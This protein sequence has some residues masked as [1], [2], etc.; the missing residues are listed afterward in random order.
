MP[1]PQEDLSQW[2]KPKTQD[3]S[4]GGAVATGILNPLATTNQKVTETAQPIKE[5]LSKWASPKV[6]AVN[7]IM[8]TANMFHEQAQP[9]NLIPAIAGTAATIGT[10]GLASSLGWSAGKAM[11][12]RILAN[13]MVNFGTQAT[14]N[15]DYVKEHPGEA[16][17]G[18]GVN[19]LGSEGVGQGINWAAGGL[20]NAILRSQFPINRT[21]EDL[22]LLR[23]APPN[24]PYTVG[25]AQGESNSALR[26]NS[27]SPKGK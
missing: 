19:A 4:V 10:D 8:K 25:Q 3:S 18:A 1:D 6:G 13:S 9:E 7:T 2:A 12:A 24:L 15:T 20:R 17:L 5:D 27:Y 22:Q 14:F 11:L 21:P 26:E 16:A 23:S